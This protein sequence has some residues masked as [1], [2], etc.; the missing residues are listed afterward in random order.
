M[1]P[2]PRFEYEPVTSC[3]RS[4]RLAPV[5]SYR[6]SEGMKKAPHADRNSRLRGEN[7]DRSVGPRPAQPPSK[8][9]T[10]SKIDHDLNAICNAL[11]MNRLV[12]GAGADLEALRGSFRT[13]KNPRASLRLQTHNILMEVRGHP[14]LRRLPLMTS[15]PKPH[16][17][18]KYCEFHEQNG[19]T[20][21]GCR[22]LRKALHELADNCQIDRF[23]K[24]SPR[25]LW[26]EYEPM[27]PDPKIKNAPRR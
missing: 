22:K 12:R 7:P 15:A 9:W 4:H 1:R 10:A 17:A 18:R 6:H 19:H 2:L 26:Q 14:M 8:P 5:V 13:T 25:F 3:K 16:N 11:P 23:L 24:K 21:A 27:R 20:T